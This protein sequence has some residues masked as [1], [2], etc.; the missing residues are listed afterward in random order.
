MISLALKWELVHK[1]VH[2]DPSLCTHQWELIPY[3]YIMTCHLHSD[4]NFY[5]WVHYD[6]SLFT[7]TWELYIHECIVTCHSHS[8]RTLPKWV[9]YN[10]II[11]TQMRTCAYNVF[12][13]IITCHYLHSKKEL[14]PKWVHY[15]VLMH[16]QMTSICRFHLQMDNFT[17]WHLNGLIDSSCIENIWISF[18]HYHILKNRLEHSQVPKSCYS[19]KVHNMIGVRYHSL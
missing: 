11:Y 6:L 3:K 2:C 13:Y 14:V 18:N 9:H 16:T 17:P 5:K 8:I 4:E 12:D 15:N 1:W 7:V 19:E 10:V